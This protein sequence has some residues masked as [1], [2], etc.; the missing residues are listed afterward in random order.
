[1]SP[2]A[3]ST[4][5]IKLQHALLEKC[6]SLPDQHCIQH[7]ALAVHGSVAAAWVYINRYQ[8]W[9][10][11]SSQKTVQ[12]TVHVVHIARSVACKSTGGVQALSSQTCAQQLKAS[13]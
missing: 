5:L 7:V 1:M 4:L 3:F 8:F 2:A 6:I 13:S 12:W 11:K 9:H 10:V